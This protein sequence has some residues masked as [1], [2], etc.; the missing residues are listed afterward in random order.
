MAIWKYSC[1]PR[2]HSS[3]QG[4]REVKEG[5]FP[6]LL[7]TTHKVQ[8]MGAAGAEGSLSWLS[9]PGSNPI[10]T[11]AEFPLHGPRTHL[12]KKVSTLTAHG[13][14]PGTA[15]AKARLMCP[16]RCWTGGA[17]GFQGCPKPSVVAL[18]SVLDLEAAGMFLVSHSPVTFC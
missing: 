1:S 15:G 3:W 18:G 10:S 4:S 14:A 13:P 2:A 6:C 16:N 9:H 17:A 5:H 7:Q 12:D 11:C 8:W